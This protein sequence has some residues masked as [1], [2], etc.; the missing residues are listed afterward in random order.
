MS[1]MYQYWKP[2]LDVALHIDEALSTSQPINEQIKKDILL[3]HTRAI[4]RE[5]F[6]LFGLTTPTTKKAVLHHIYKVFIGDS[7]SSANLLQS[8]NDERVQVMFD[9]E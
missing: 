1:H 4:W 8:E 6:Q 5:A 9:L 3:F 2:P 7:S